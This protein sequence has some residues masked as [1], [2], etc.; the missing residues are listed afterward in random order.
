MLL[1]KMIKVRNEVNRAICNK[2]FR[3]TNVRIILLR[4]KGVCFEDNKT[5]KSFFNTPT[6]HPRKE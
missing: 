6:Q 4:S 5:T 2:I 3:W 1:I